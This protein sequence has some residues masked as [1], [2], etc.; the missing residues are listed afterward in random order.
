MTLQQR[1][2]SEQAVDRDFKF[3]MQPRQ[4]AAVET[5]T[6]GWPTRASAANEYIK[7]WLDE[8]GKALTRLK[9]SKDTMKEIA[10]HTSR[11]DGTC[12]MT[13]RSLSARSG[14][15][16]ASTKRDI[17]RL[18]KLGF[19][20]AEYEGGD[21]KQERVRVLKLSLPISPRSSQRIPPVL[22]AEVV[23]TYPA[24]VDPLD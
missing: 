2:S 20:V 9:L 14:R 21:S 3:T 6:F 11:R 16:L 23:S 5:I 1:I 10:S 4:F 24:Y 12:R 7:G 15:A 22:T 19:I 17:Y 8:A 18:K 13:D